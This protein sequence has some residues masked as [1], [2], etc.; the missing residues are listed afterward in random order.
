MLSLNDYKNI[1]LS[2]EDPSINIEEALNYAMTHQYIDESFEEAFGGLSLRRPDR[3]YK[4]IL[5]NF[6][7]INRSLGYRLSMEELISLAPFVFFEDNIERRGAPFIDFIDFLRM[8]TKVYNVAPSW[9][10]SYSLNEILPE[11]L[12][13]LYHKLSELNQTF[14]L[15]PHTIINYCY[16]QTSSGACSE[17]FNLWYEFVASIPHETNES[18][19]PENLLFAFNTAALKNG[20]TTTIFKLTEYS[21]GNFFFRKHGNTLIVR[22]AIPVNPETNEVC[23]EWIKLWLDHV[24]EIEV[25]P[26]ADH[27]RDNELPY[28]KLMYELTINLTPNS[29]VMVDDNDVNVSPRLPGQVK[30]SLFSGT[31]WICYYEG[32]SRVDFDSERLVSLR[33]ARNLTQKEAAQAANTKARTLQYWES[34]RNKAYPDMI[35]LFRLMVL[36]DVYD[37]K[38]FIKVKKFFD[39]G[40]EKYRSGASLEEM[41]PLHYNGELE[42]MEGLL[43]VLEEFQKETDKKGGD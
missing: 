33:K 30:N 19:T 23:Y 27:R 37:I 29:L 35:S 18:L 12:G 14:G 39:I 16:E 6:I 10:T 24:G 15:D 9:K 13:P 25:K 26:L 3:T 28:G 38:T 22:A 36:Y 17:L 42:P 32:P 4:Y 2:M 1:L 7:N 11:N 43:A 31:D 8:V 5:S 34:K 41:Y 21:G 40:D 20:E